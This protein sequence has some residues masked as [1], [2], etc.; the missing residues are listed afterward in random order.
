MDNTIIQF[1]KESL[2]KLELEPRGTVSFGKSEDG[3]T[4]FGVSSHIF[5]KDG[6]TLLVNISGITKGDFD[7]CFHVAHTQTKEDIVKAVTETF[8]GDGNVA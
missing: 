4:T 2:N 8:I 6:R 7:I 1:I 3:K 5:V